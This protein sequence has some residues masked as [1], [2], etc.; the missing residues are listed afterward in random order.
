MTNH[1]VYNTEGTNYY[2]APHNWYHNIYL[3]NYYY[4]SY[5]V[6]KRLINWD[7]VTTYSDIG[8]GTYWLTQRLGTN[9]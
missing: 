1:S 9:G 5:H 7:L 3:L 6:E 8:L 2:M 4:Y